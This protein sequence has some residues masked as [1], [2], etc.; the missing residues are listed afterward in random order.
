MTTCA[1]GYCS[2]EVSKFQ[3]CC[4]HALTW[5]LTPEARLTGNAQ[6]A[7]LRDFVLRQE[8]RHTLKQK[9]VTR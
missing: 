9:E 3:L 7:A 2:R 1:V 6:R 4:I 5:L 8:I